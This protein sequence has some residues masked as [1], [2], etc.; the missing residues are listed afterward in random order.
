LGGRFGWMVTFTLRGDLVAASRFITAARRIPFCPS[1]GDLCTTLTH[2]A[3]TSHRLLSPEAKSKLGI[4]DGT[5]RLSVGIESS[6]FVLEALQEGLS[7]T[8]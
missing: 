7:G 1:L 6:E 4:L 3:S 8:A 2:P 5:I